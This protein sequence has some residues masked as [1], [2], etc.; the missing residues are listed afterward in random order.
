MPVLVLD[1]CYNGIPLETYN[2]YFQSVK[3]EQSDNNN[4]TSK[5]HHSSPFRGLLLEALQ[6]AQI[7]C[8]ILQ[9]S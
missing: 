1:D 6:S 9:T 3:C 8:P 4:R 5:I 7:P 2:F